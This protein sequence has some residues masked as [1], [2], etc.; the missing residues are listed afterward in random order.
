MICNEIRLKT[1]RASQDLLDRGYKPKQVFN[2][3]ASNSENVVPIVFASFCI[4]C[5][6]AALHTTID[7]IEIVRIWQ[8]VRIWYNWLTKR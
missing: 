5:P 6:I 3:I 4:G 8:K 2:F 1:I 7:K